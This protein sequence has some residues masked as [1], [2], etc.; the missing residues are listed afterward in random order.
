M[1]T[2]SK[3]NHTPRP[4]GSVFYALTP[5]GKEH[6][7]E[8]R[9]LSIKLYNALK[10]KANGVSLIELTKKTKRFC[11]GKTPAATISARVSTWRADGLVKRII[12]KKASGISLVKAAA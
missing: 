11:G 7:A 3:K 2:K 9:G 12:N 10:G 5:K 8:T 1:A 6:L 4:R